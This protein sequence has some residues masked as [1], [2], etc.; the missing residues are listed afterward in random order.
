MLSVRLSRIPGNQIQK[1]KMPTIYKPKSKRNNEGKRKERMKIYNSA[2]WRELR[3]LKL[4]QDPLCE[5][6]KRN[7]IVTLATDVHHKQSFM[8]YHDTQT[9]NVLAFS[10]DNLMS[11]CDSCH[12]KLH[13]GRARS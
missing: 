1:R 2:R 12:S 10:M 7:G 5:M 3:R 4:S 13:N 9:R 6:C 11:L 8:D